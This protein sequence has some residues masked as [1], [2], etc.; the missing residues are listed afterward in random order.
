MAC[1]YFYPK[2]DPL[3]TLESLPLP[4]GDAW[5]GFC[6]ASA[7]GPIEPEP[8]LLV[9]H[10]HLGYARGRCAH[11]P[12]NDAGP[13]AVRFAVSRLSGAGVDLYYVQEREHHPF[14]HG[15]LRY[16]I[17]LRRFLN[18]APS[19]ILA[20]QAEA[21]VESYLRRQPEPSHI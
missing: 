5:T 3:P 12:G 15:P 18:E 16:S 13:D 8:A 19:H 20:R 9:A 2:P 4:L 1:P 11:F 17:A 21:Y 14:A 10:C 7:D 6:H